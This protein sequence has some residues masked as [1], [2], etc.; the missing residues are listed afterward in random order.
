MDKTKLKKDEVILGTVK[1][2]I[3]RMIGW[4]ISSVVILSLLVL[5]LVLEFNDLS[6]LYNVLFIVFISL[7]FLL[8]GFKCFGLIKK[9]HINE[10]V[11]TT[12]N[13]YVTGV[14]VLRVKRASI[15]YSKIVDVKIYVNGL[16]KTYDIEIYSNKTP[17]SID[18]SNKDVSIVI[19]NISKRDVD[20]IMSVINKY[21]K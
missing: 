3:N 8:L 2:I 17:L 18:Q 16:F 12:K 10:Y 19:D 21:K 13:I 7:L 6:T 1:P 11:L 15:S 9:Y 4:V 14:D 20:F 5:I